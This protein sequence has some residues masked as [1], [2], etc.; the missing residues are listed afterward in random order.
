MIHLG[1]DADLSFYSFENAYKKLH[2]ITKKLPIGII[3]SKEDKTVINEIF[4]DWTKE[5]IK[6]DVIESLPLDMWILYNHIDAVYS[7][8]A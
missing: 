3:I 7:N 5:K 8:G 6:V 2:E 4:L 1:I